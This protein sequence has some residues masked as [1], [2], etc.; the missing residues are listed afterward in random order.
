VRVI[1]KVAD[2]YKLDRRTKRTFRA[3]AA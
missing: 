2:A 3:D 1:K